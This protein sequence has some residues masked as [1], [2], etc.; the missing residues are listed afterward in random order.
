MLTNGPRSGRSKSSGPKFCVMKRRTG[1]SQTRAMRC[2]EQDRSSCTE[3]APTMAGRNSIHR[4]HSTEE[5]KASFWVRQECTIRN[6]PFKTKWCLVTGH[7]ILEFPRT[8]ICKF[9]NIEQIHT[10]TS[11]NN[12]SSICAKRRGNGK[13]LKSPCKQQLWFMIFFRSAGGNVGYTAGGYN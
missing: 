11:L 4:T 5:M 1:D 13:L 10:Q 6:W 8:K 7:L 9:T 3:L 12:S 2:K